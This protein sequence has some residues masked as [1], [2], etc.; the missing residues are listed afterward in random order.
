MILLSGLAACS[1]DSSDGAEPE[2][3]PTA[4]AAETSSTKVDQDAVTALYDRYWDVRV[5]AENAAEVD[6]ASFAGIAEGPFVE[7]FLKKVRD[8][9]DIDVTREGQPTIDQVEVT[10]DGDTA[11]VAACLDEDD[12][13]FFG[14]GTE[15]DAPDEGP[16]P[17]GA[18]AERR[19][20]G[21]I[22]TGAVE[23]AN[24]GKDCA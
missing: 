2:P 17:V 15:I 24:V 23:A 11:T 12:W 19:P 18:T 6:P 20:E 21:W 9:A 10:V 22:L 16:G 3:S 8:A 7:E 1:S 13:K 14:N 5:E 4:T